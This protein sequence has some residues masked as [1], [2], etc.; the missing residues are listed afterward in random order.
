MNEIFEQ[1]ERAVAKIFENSENSEVYICGHSAGAH[2]A[3]MLLY[4]DFKNKY[5]VDASNLKGIISVS[6]IFDLRPLLETDVNENLKMN[7]EESSL[8]SPLLRN[9][10]RLHKN[11]AF[12]IAYAENDSP[13]FHKQSEDFKI[14]LTKCHGY[15]DVTSIKIEN[16]DH[17]D[18]IEN[19]SLNSFS[20]TKVMF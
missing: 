3:T 10:I 5:N 6:G 18:I 17:F 1:V 9:D 20:L 14:Y 7:L 19:I 12:L 16:V 13:A 2:L 4:S 8:L 11:V 15:Q